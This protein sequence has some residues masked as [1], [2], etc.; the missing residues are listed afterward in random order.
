MPN[1][2]NLVNARFGRL[3]AKHIAD[4]YSVLDKRS[5]RTNRRARWLCFCDCG[6]EVIVRQTDLRSGATVSCGCYR[7]E[8]S[9]RKYSKLWRLKKNVV[10]LFRQSDGRFGQQEK[11]A[12]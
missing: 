6:S 4:F 7:N 12:A 1:Q 3:V 8:V 9:S 11:E 2:L 10:E 5:G